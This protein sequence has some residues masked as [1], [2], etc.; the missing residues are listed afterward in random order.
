MRI[1]A[2]FFA[3]VFSTQLLAD[4]QSCSD[5]ELKA[6]NEYG[7]AA[8]E[9]VSVVNLEKESTIDVL[10]AI[11][12]DDGIV[13]VGEFN[14]DDDYEVEFDWKEECNDGGLYFSVKG[15]DEIDDGIEYLRTKVVLWLTCHI[16]SA[17][18]ARYRVAAG[19]CSK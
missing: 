7:N 16:D 14:T 5:I 11:E 3:F 19:Y 8:G 13:P 2:T 6:M 10:Q 1:L 17:P 9:V 18:N 4:Y 15:Y 12:L